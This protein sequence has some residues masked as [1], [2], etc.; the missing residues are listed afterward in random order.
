MIQ[1]LLDLR[2]LLEAR[3]LP[4][5]ALRELQTAR[6]RAT[7]RH[8]VDNV[9]FYRERFRAAGVLPETIR[10]PEDLHRLPVTTK[11]DLVAAGPD[12]VA[13]DVDLSA[14]QRRNTS[15]STGRPL[16]VPATAAEARTHDL[17]VFRTLL[18]MGLR[19]FDRLAVV[20]AVGRHETRLYQRLGLFRSIN[21]SRFQS[22]G[23]QLLALQRY[24]PTFVWAYAT[25]LRRLLPLV[26]DQLSRVIR[27]RV[28][29]NAG[30]VLDPQLRARL[31][32]DLDA[33]FCGLYGSTEVGIVAGECRS[34]RGLHVHADRLLLECLGADGPAAAG[35]RGEAVVTCLG[36]RAM[37]MIRYR[38]G[39]VFRFIEEPCPC[40]SAFPLIEAP[41]GREDD[42]LRLPG[43]R[44]LYL[45]ECDAF[46]GCRE[47]LQY[48]FVQE[49]PTRFRVQVQL[50]DRPAAHV[51]AQVHE[52]LARYLGEEV[53]VELDLLQRFPETAI[54][55]RAF[56]PLGAPSR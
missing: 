25:V 55:F 14:C 28:F 12:A 7:I 18:D 44:R 38:V 27:P 40:G 21:V 13:R 26:D 51:V 34:R 35:G 17:I 3:R 4:P 6:L 10:S 41:I 19:P 8:A 20:S 37:P 22:P 45:G 9:P 5:S 56:V 29:V 53:E 24:Q 39:D 49:G 2:H 33:E 54:K 47:V 15:G 52:R 50:R 48:R 46:V 32:D 16:R 11:A 36:R 30:E 23:E 43:G 1:R 42:A 31:R